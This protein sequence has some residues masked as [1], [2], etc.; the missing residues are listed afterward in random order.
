MKL[1][2]KDAN[3]ALG[4]SWNQHTGDDNPSLYSQELIRPGLVVEYDDGTR[5]IVGHMNAARGRCD[6]CNRGGDRIVRR[7]AYLPEFE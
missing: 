5:E 6:C 3:V 2:W 4:P 7:Y 1:D